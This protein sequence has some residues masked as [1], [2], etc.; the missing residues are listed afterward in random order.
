MKTAI[1]MKICDTLGI[2]GSYCEIVASDFTD[3][4][5]IMGHDGP[6][7]IGIADRRP[8]LRGLGLYHGKWGSGISVEAKVKSGP[9]TNL[10]ITQTIDG[11]LKLIDPDW[12]RGSPCRGRCRFRSRWQNATG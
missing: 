7:H 11:K 12:N 2:G 9:I 5:I 1:A 10:G 3:Q 8:I 6:F 4:T